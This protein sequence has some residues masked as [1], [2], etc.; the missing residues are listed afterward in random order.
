MLWR[1]FQYLSKCHVRTSALH[2][3]LSRI[4][5]LEL[6]LSS[7]MA[8]DSYLSKDELLRFLVPCSPDGNSSWSRH[9]ADVVPQLAYVSCPSWWSDHVWKWYTICEDEAV[10]RLES[11]ISHQSR[12]QNHVGKLSVNV[13]VFVILAGTTFRKLYHCGWMTHRKC[14]FIKL[15][16]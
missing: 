12:H 14:A 16:M 2:Q 5:A 7:P 6:T 8:A 9:P 11:A 3:T 1:W 10:I 4:T 13:A 15:K